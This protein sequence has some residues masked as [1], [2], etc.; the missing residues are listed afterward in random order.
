MASKALICANDNVFNKSILQDEGLYFSSA[1]DV[2]LLVENKLKDDY[3][4]FILANNIKIEKYY[5]W[6]KIISEY[7]VQLHK[8]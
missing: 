5:T 8:I 3:S 6:H 7:E 4:N 1:N 2:T